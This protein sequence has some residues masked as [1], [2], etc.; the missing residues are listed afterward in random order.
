MT[1][2]LYLLAHVAIGALAIGAAIVGGW[3]IIRGLQ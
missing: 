1:W 2:A 3:L